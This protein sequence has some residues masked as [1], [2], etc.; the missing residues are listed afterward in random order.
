MGKKMKIKQMLF[1]VQFSDS[2][3]YFSGGCAYES[4][5]WWQVDGLQVFYLTDHL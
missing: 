3:F 1:F 2:V 5:L 4:P